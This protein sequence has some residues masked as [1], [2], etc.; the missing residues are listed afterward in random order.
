MPSIEQARAWYQNS[1]A[2]HDFDHV[3]RVYR[4]A[5]TLAEKEGADIEIVRAAA[6]LHDAE[7]ASGDTDVRMD[8]HEAAAIFAGKV[9]A[10]E[11]WEEERIKAVQYCILTHRF[12]GD[13]QP[14]SIEA[15]VLFDAD[16]LDAIGAIGAA[17]ALA[18]A[19]LDGQPLYAEP[20]MTFQKAL[21]TEPGEPYTAYHEYL[22][23]LSRLKDRI[24]TESGKAFANARHEYLKG[25]F[26]QLRAEVQ[27]QR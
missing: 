18:Y 27:G 19:V 23:K 16:K 7:S 1:D 13:R 17:R 25:F 9:L 8:H 2:V 22:F 20:S 5:E 12:R 24:Q 15:K 6:L 11:G 14:N 26:Q 21:K 3:M 10:E 4:L